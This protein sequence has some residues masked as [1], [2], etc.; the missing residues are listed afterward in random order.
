MVL[1]GAL[2]LGEV[3]FSP[4]QPGEPMEAGDPGQ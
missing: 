3:G 4:D 2:G 1:V